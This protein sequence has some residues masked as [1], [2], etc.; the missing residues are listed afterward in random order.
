MIVRCP[1]GTAV[2]ASSISDR[3]VDDPERTFGLYLDA[4]WQ[5]TWP[6]EVVDWEDFGLPENP[7]LAAQQIADAFDRAQRGE[8]VE[9]GCLGGNGRTGTA[10]ACMTVLAGVPPADAVGWV[11]NA[12]RP[13]AVETVEQEAWVQWF[14]DWA[15]S[16]DRIAR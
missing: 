11:R 4:Q 9:V 12:Y 5:P 16:V 7:E 2:R 14:A 3:R 10:P 1:D 15:A 8:L 13:Q 6:A